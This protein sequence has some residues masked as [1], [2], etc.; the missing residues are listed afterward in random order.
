LQLSETA[1]CIPWYWAE[2]SCDNRPVIM[3]LLGW[4]SIVEFQ[5]R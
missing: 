1:I 2:Y 3:G 5:E 4:E